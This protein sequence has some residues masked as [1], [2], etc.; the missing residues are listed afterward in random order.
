MIKIQAQKR[1]TRV[2]GEMRQMPL[3][4][5]VG[6]WAC[7]R[8]V[9]LFGV[10]PA[11]FKF[12][13]WI[14]Y[15]GNFF[16]FLT[17]DEWIFYLTP[18]THFDGGAHHLGFLARG[19]DLLHEIFYGGNGLT[20]ELVISGDESKRFRKVIIRLISHSIFMMAGLPIGAVLKAQGIALNVA[21]DLVA[22]MVGNGA[23]LHGGHV[24]AFLINTNT[25][26]GGNVLQSRHFCFFQKPGPVQFFHP[27]SCII[28][29]KGSWDKKLSHIS[30]HVNRA[31]YLLQ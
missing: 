18:K 6:F 21:E 1:Y 29:K 30:H 31:Y 8:K 28:L 22:N 17:I 20:S 23:N 25:G 19:V 3:S 12:Y 5:L 27:H 11:G 9:R 14:Y 13:E 24:N 16:I 26:V 7:R 10:G 2:R 4:Y 15:N